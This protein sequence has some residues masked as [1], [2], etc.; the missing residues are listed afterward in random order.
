[1][2]RFS[3]ILS[4][5]L[6]FLM[7][8]SVISF[9]TINANADGS[10]GTLDDF[11]ERCYTVTLDRPS[12]PPG[13]AD[14][15]DQL[16]NGKAVG[17]EIAYGFL[18]SKEYT[19]KNKDNDAYLKDLYML[20]MGREP[21]PSGYN[22]WMGKLNSG[23]SRLE[24]FAG[25]ANSQEFYNICESYGITAG[26]YVIGYDR[27]SIN[28]VNLYVE[29]MYKICLERIGDKGGQADWVEKLLKK[30]ITGTE[31]ARR[32]IFSQEYKNKGLSDEE[33]VENLYLAMMGRPYD[34][35]GKANWLN[36][37]ASGKT[38]DQ[39]FEGFANSAEFAQICA[40]YKIDKGSYKATDI[41]NTNQNNNN[42][43]NNNQNQNQAANAVVNYSNTGNCTIKDMSASVPAK[44]NYKVGDVIK[45]GKYEQDGNSSN[46]KEDIE[47]VVAYV[48]DWDVIVVSKY[49]LDYQ[50]YNTK[51]ADT[52]WENS[53]LRKWLNNDF[54]NA[55]FSKEEQKQIPSVPVVNEYKNGEWQY[56][57]DKLFLMCRSDIYFTQFSERYYSG[58]N[59]GY[60]N[61]FICEPTKYCI[62]KGAE[63]SSITQTDYKNY[64]NQYYSSNVVGKKGTEYWI[65]S[66]YGQNDNKCW[67]AGSDGFYG[68]N[69]MKKVNNKLAVR[70]VMYLSYHKIN[71]PDEDAE[72]ELPKN[73]K[74][75]DTF[76]YGRYEQDNNEYDGKE[77]IEWIV[78]ETDGHRAL[79]VS[80]YVLD[81]KKAYY[82]TSGDVWWYNNALQSWLNNE[83]VNDAF[84]YKERQ[85]IPDVK[86]DVKL[87]FW[88]HEDEYHNLEDQIFCLSNAEL[89][90]YCGDYQMYF[91][92][93]NE[94]FNENFLASP[95]PYAIKQGVQ[96]I[97][98]TEE[99]YNNSSIYNPDTGTRT[100]SYKDF[101]SRNVVGRVCASYWKRE[102]CATLTASNVGTNVNPD[103]REGV[104]FFGDDFDYIGTR[105]AMYIDY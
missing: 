56:T 27:Q 80:R 41:G 70:P 78:L 54:Y 29:R 19:N 48:K 31:C 22:D 69:H 74:A 21:D 98:I 83:F 92:K 90:K 63:V 81:C 40:T 25:F 51:D 12:D 2:K 13:F 73:I 52:S 32:F 102:N 28:N 1:M 4:L 10:A 101:Y 85:H 50:P 91:S 6:S 17:I 103:G 15:K 68:D 94:G 84:T 30:Q 9:P 42:N 14:W 57:Q 87:P 47:W 82:S 26:R 61:K 45:F 67:Y 44:P 24:V 33:F 77:P 53:S 76:F 58:V 95:T 96:T 66:D 46:G 59:Q 7:V 23:V 62:S 104:D 34:E 71:E 38:R 86:V 20:F 5:F 65:R 8:L 11:V 16:L 75:G 88:A 35:G 3:K 36:A 105:P 93:Y 72:P 43:N 37:L 89:K 49:A 64:Y 99:V 18:F 97:T 55:A 39:V 100:T 60:G 79:V